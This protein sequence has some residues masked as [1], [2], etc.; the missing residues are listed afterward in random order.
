MTIELFPTGTL[1]CVARLLLLPGTLT[2]GVRVVEVVDCAVA[3]AKPLSDPY[4][5]DK[6]E[7]CLTAFRPGG[8]LTP[9]SIR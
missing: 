1:D 3:G 2:G 9:D 8:P 4:L 7:T 5:V 6:V